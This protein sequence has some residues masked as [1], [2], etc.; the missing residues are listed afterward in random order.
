VEKVRKGE[1]VLEG[2]GEAGAGGFSAA[3]LQKGGSTHSLVSSGSKSTSRHEAGA[4]R[5]C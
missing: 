2:N 3:L 5:S 4:S 1:V